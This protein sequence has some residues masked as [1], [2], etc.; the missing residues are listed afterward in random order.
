MT[1]PEP[2]I[3]L[4]RK[5]V[6]WVETQD[7]LPEIDREWEQEVYLSPPEHR[8]FK[9][10]RLSGLTAL[11]PYTIRPL[12]DRL[13]PHCG[14][15]Y[16]VAGH[17]AATIDSRYLT[18]EAVDYPHGFEYLGRAVHSSVVAKEAMGL[19]GAQAGELFAGGNTARDIRRVAENVAGERL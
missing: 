10:I 14:T 9:M 19:T 5:A 4:L 13:A 6:E 11:D 16:C 15:G 17:I 8:A 18:T 7:A 2:N 12:V 1:T 3:P